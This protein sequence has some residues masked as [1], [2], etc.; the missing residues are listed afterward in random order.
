MTENE[1]EGTKLSV[2]TNLQALRCPMWAK[3]TMKQH[4]IC[5]LGKNENHL[6]QIHI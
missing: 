6:I 4:K 3:T 2:S 1:E 5:G